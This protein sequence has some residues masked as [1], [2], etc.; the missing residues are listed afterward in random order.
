LSYKIRSAHYG[1]YIPD[2]RIKF[3]PEDVDW[4]EQNVHVRVFKRAHFKQAPVILYGMER[5]VANTLPDNDAVR[6]WIEGKMKLHYPEFCKILGWT[7]DD[8]EK[9]LVI[10][11]CQRGIVKHASNKSLASWQFYFAYALQMVEIFL[12]AHEVMPEQKYFCFRLEDFYLTS[13]IK[14]KLNLSDWLFAW[15]SLFV[16][17]YSDDYRPNI[18]RSNFPPELTTV[19]GL[20]INKQTVDVWAI[21]KNLQHLMKQLFVAPRYWFSYPEVFPSDCPADLTEFMKKCTA[22]EPQD[23]PKLNEL[24]HMLETI[25][26]NNAGLTSPNVNGSTLAKS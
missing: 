8:E 1:T 5:I 24:K 4:N 16:I 15:I 12:K 9:Y 20:K 6:T 2:Y 18:S 26:H 21:A 22:R 17:N 23:R 14:L 11:N 10:E 19:E 7:G 13:E 3:S 25:A